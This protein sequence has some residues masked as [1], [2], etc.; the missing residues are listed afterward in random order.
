MKLTRHLAYTLAALLLG[1]SVAYGAAMQS[2]YVSPYPRKVVVQ[3]HPTPSASCSAVVIAPRRLLTAAHCVG[4]KMTF[5][6]KPVPLLV[7][8]SDTKMD[9]ALLEAEVDCP[10]API[11]TRVDLDEPVVVIGFPYYGVGEGEMD[12]QIVTHGEAQGVMP[13]GKTMV[14]ALASPGNSG[15]GVFVRRGDEWHLVGIVSAIVGSG[16]RFGPPTH[17]HMTIIAGPD[18]VAA[19]LKL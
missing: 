16:T 8:K 1:L 7:L 18:M 12:R 17:S 5:R 6:G 3:F 15:G 9:L 10:C 14:S 2:Q 11:G 4:E 19:F 13:S